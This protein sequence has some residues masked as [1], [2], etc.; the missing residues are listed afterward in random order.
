MELQVQKRTI[1]GRGVK[2]LRKQGL[3]PAELYG[4]GVE[5]LHLTV[6]SKEFKKVFKEAGENTLVNLLIEKEK[7]PVLINN[8]SF[9]YLSG[10][11]ESVDFYQVRMGEKLKVKVPL[12]FIGVAPAVKEKNGILVKSLQEL[13]VEVLPMD[14][15]HEFKVDLSK[16][17]NI[18]QSIYIKD[19][20]VPEQVKVLV[21]PETVVVTVIAK[22]TEEEELAIQQ[23]AAGRGVEAI[24]VETEEKKAEREA[25]KA[26]VEQSVEATQLVKEGPKK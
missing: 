15:P 19:L 6:S 3:V 22:I 7:R 4:K 18:G 23:E 20:V 10:D 24:K 2:A 13:E 16:L 11:V 1:L 21:A 9:N 25:A 14:I 8:V 17:A 5:N 12:E 26:V